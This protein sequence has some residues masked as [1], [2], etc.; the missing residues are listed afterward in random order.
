MKQ[1]VGVGLLLVVIRMSALSSAPPDLS[2]NASLSPQQVVE[3]Q[4][5][6]LRHNNEPTVDAGIERSFRFASPSNRLVTGPLSHFSEI[7]HSATYS[8]LLGSQGSEV[9]GVI[10]QG[11]EAKVYVTVTSATGSQLNFLFMLSRQGQG[12]YRDCWMTDSVM[13][14][15]PEENG[16][17]IAI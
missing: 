7:V 11:N 4:L 6:A 15:P 16:N 17:Q 1:L 8:A 2:P 10:V 14:L 5:D 3:F 12:D 9:R 13:K